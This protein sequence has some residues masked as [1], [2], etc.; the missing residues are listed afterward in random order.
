MKKTKKY[1]PNKWKAYSDVPA[2]KYVTFDFEDLMMM[3]DEWELRR[4]HVCVIRETTPTGRVKEK[5]YQRVH[6][7]KKK[8]GQLIKDSR[9]FT[10]LTYDAMPHISPE[11]LF[12]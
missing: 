12:Q 5:A 11:N 7:A 1:F 10:V 3:K 4:S 9:E 6:A 8:V 2:D